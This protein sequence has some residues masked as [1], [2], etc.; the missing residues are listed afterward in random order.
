MIVLS[1]SLNLLTHIQIIRVIIAAIVPKQ[2]E[3]AKETLT[4]ESS[5]ESRPKNTVFAGKSD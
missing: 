4:T 2:R 3:G 1:T 5:E